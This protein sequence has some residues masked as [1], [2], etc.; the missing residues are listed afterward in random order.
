MKVLQLVLVFSLSVFSFS[1][2][3]AQDSVNVSSS[4]FYSDTL[5][6]NS[7]VIPVHLIIENKSNNVHKDLIVQGFLRSNQDSAFLDI[8]GISLDPKEVLDT[9]VE[10]VLSAKDDDVDDGLSVTVLDSS[11]TINSN[12]A[13]D[14]FYLIYSDQPALIELED[15]SMDSLSKFG[16]YVKYN[17]NVVNKRRVDYFN[18]N[19]VSYMFQ[20]N[21]QAASQE[22]R[23]LEEVACLAHQKNTIYVEDSFKVEDTYLKKGGKNIVV[24]W[25]VGFLKTDSLKQKIKIDW[26][27]GI[28]PKNNSVSWSLYPNPASDLL[29]IEINENIEQ[30]RVLDMAGREIDVEVQGKIVSIEALP[31]G[32]Y[33]LQIE[34]KKGLSQRLFSIIGH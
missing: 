25:P 11:R 27:I 15:F 7:D 14:S 24:V 1:A 4:L 23:Y 17:F 33:M 28:R 31:N 10:I 26:G 13:F 22:E 16:S 6:V 5:R 9:F 2:L 3:S 34:T 12:T 8:K 18:K 20:F 32:T 29:I 21:N 30:V 19:G